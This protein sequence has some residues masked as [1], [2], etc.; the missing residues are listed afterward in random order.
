MASPLKRGQSG[1]Q[2]TNQFPSTAK[3]TPSDLVSTFVPHGLRLQ[4][5]VGQ[6]VITNV[7]AAGG[8]VT[9]TAA[10]N[11]SAGDVVSIYYVNPTAY[12]LFNVTV[13]SA[14]S[15]QFTVTN[16]ATGTYVSGG[17]A[18]RTGFQ[19]VTIPT[20][21]NWVYT[22]MVG[23]GGAG[24]N[25]RGGAGG[26][27]AWG[28]TLAQ[29]TCRIAAAF[30]YG[31]TEYTRYGHIIAG[32]GGGSNINP[33]LGGGGAQD[34]GNGA[35][36]YWGMP[37]GASNTSGAGRPGAGGGYGTSGGGDGIS[38]GGGGSQTNTF[39]N[40]GSGLVGGSGNSGGTGGNGLGIDGTVY[41]GAVGGGAGMAGNATGDN[42]GLGG[43][44]A[45]GGGIG[46][47]GILYIFY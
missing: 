1:N 42:G 9:Y 33:I 19:S 38:G 16:G 30:G 47:A 3:H 20:G 44:G 32:W 27:V 26:G 2:V 13:A 22:V 34:G 5:K 29:S 23:G 7:T 4:Q 6:V 15:T 24:A 11:Y 39:G 18:Q 10:N 21:I 31:G 40:G 8:T 17:I 25:G 28:W 41:T 35:T 43:G 14:S 37:G 12:N 46:G 36:N 45:V